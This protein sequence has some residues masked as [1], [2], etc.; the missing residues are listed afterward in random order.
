MRHFIIKRSPSNDGTLRLSYRLE[1]PIHHSIVHLKS[2][3]T[4]YPGRLYGAEI[5]SNDLRHRVFFRHIDSPNSRTS[6]EIQDFM[7]CIKWGFMKLF[8][9]D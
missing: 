5:R 4:R 1:S 2:A 6:T 7:R 9:S 3:V 8:I